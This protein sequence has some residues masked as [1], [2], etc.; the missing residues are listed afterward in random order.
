[1]STEITNWLRGLGLEQYASAFEDNAIDAGVLPELTADDLKDLGVNLVG[2]RR[3][4]LAAI[5]ALRDQASPAE[6]RSASAPSL[7]LIPNDPGPKS[8]TPAERRQLTVM[9]CDLVGSTALSSRLD[10][11]DLREVI[12]AYHRCVAD[13]VGR[14]EGFVAK[15]MGDGVLVYFG[16]PRAHEDDAERAVRAGIKLRKAVRRLIVDDVTALAVRVGID[17]GLVVVGDLIGEGAAREQAVVGETPNLAARLQTLAGPNGVVIGPG[18]H[19]LVA[20]LFELADLGENE[21][22]GF[23]EKIPAWRVQG[24]SRAESRFAARSATGLTPFIGRQHELGMLLDRFE[25]AKDGEGQIVLLSGEPGIGKSRLAHALLE[26]LADEPHTRLRYYC[27]LFHVNSAL[28]PIIEQFERAAAFEGDDRPERKLDK[29]EALLSRATND[30]AE[31]TPLLAALL[32]IPSGTRYAP[33]NMPAQRQRELTIAALLDQLGGLAAHQPVLMVL[34]DSQWLDPTSTEL[35][36]RVIERVQTLPVLL[37]ITSRPEFA[38]PWISY[39][40]MTS[41]T[42]NR[43]GRRHSTEMIAAVAGG[44]PLPEAILA[45]IWAR[46]GGVPLFV[47]ELTKTVLEAGLLEDKGD[48]YE[49]TG[50]LPP[51]AIP[52]TLQDSLMAR[53]DRFAPVKEVAQIGA[54][55][56]REFSYEL[57]AALSPLD[58]T[59]LQE[60]LSQ[61]IGSELAFRRGTIPNAIYSFKH[62]FVQEA[63]YRSLLKSKRQQ[64]HAKVAAALRERLAETIGSQPEILA[65]HLTEA[66]LTAEAM[67]CWQHAGQLAAERSANAEATAHLHRG[68]ELLRALPESSERNEQELDLLTTLGSLLM[69]TKGHGHAEVATVYRRARDLCRSEGDTSR[70]AAVLQGLRLHH[71]YRAELALAREAAEELLAL[72]EE[73]GES[74]Y[75]VEGERA[76]GVVRFFAG[77]F[78]AAGDHLERGITLYDIQAHGRHALRYVEDPGE[79]CLTYVARALWVLGYPDQAVARSEQAIAVAQTIAHA[80]SIA[81]AM[82]W[83]ADIALHRREVLDARERAAAALALAIEHGMP[84]RTGMASMMH[85]WALSEQGQSAD[86]VAQIREGLSVLGGTGDQLYRPYSLARLAEALGKTGQVEEGLSALDEAI[87][88]SRKSGAAYWDAELQRRKGELLLAAN[89]VERAAAEACF[90]RAIDIAQAQSAKSLELRAAISLA[91]LLAKQGQRRQAHDLL[92]PIYGWFTEGFATADLKEAKALLDELA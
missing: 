33:L 31:V 1:M 11:E 79:T 60:A 86:G 36:E 49:L 47:E 72:G 45:Q 25:Q 17:T 6:T 62:A 34:E 23:G 5:A 70:L 32:S 68:L 73:T 59:A 44:K 40:H 48:R 77:E 35:F 58:E 41:L 53:L 20:G 67:G 38:S 42:L 56:G 71:M 37:L 66:G 22:K 29:L 18:T 12:G 55:I 14:Y 88:S 30:V 64:L 83:R 91:R 43:L 84:M 8:M 61:L 54:V 92:A 89:G 2:H 52:S 80:A 78:Q 9:F 51:L 65:H 3:K 39:P 63:A 85:G 82:V 81:E 46:T 69:S 19:R 13:T 50:P 76:V 27:S 28:H 16:Y 21:L 15:Y 57:L 10:P 26:R 75:L 90:R 24:D 87:D 4:L 7:P 74:G